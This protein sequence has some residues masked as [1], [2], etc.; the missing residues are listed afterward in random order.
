MKA[1]NLKKLTEPTDY[2]KGLGH[3]PLSTPTNILLFRR[4]TKDKL[5]QAA[6]QNRSHHRYVLIFN[7]ETLGHIHLNNR[8]IALHPSQALLILPYQFHHFSQLESP[9]LNWLFCTFE[10]TTAT[11]FLEPLR[12]SLVNTSPHTRQTR[13][14]LLDEW[15]RANTVASDLQNAQL[16]A[17]L[18]RVLLSLK[19]DHWVAATHHTPEPQNNL[20]RNINRCM[21][22][23]K[24]RPVGV[25]DLAR[26]L[27][28]SESRLR[29]RFK[30][31]AG[32]PLGSYIQNYRLNRAMALLRTTKLPIAEVAEEA[33]FGS[34]QAFC[35]LFKKELGLTPRTYRQQR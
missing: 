12:N 18:L 26:E 5:Q 21:S 28:L 33:G 10:L 20:L 27:N 11:T 4:T 16:Q 13:T 30:Q 1:T 3:S 31:A 15:L 19:H 24:G 8:M 35:R 9:Q 6:L 14:E 2:F 34:P 25:S 7:L 22:E 23:W 17:T 32:I 29:A